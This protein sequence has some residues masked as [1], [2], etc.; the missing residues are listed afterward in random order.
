MQQGEQLED[1]GLYAGP[2]S[3]K[4]PFGWPGSWGGSCWLTHPLRTLPCRP[5][6]AV[7]LTQGLVLSHIPG[8]LLSHSPSK[9]PFIN[10]C[11]KASCLQHR[12]RSRRGSSSS[13]CQGRR[14][15]SRPPSKPATPA[16]P[17]FPPPWDRA[18]AVQE[19]HVSLGSCCLCSGWHTQM[20]GVSVKLIRLC[21]GATCVCQALC[22]YTAPDP[23][24]KSYVRSTDQP[25]CKPENAMQQ[26]SF[27]VSPSWAAA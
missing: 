1:Q 26:V 6:D 13:S 7:Q 10:N 21:A 3:A 17:S 22:A 23:A 8:S 27:S 20:L 9:A 24:G 18:G 11:Q 14:R 5:P 2:A 4:P 12:I 19:P 15:R 16:C 25:A